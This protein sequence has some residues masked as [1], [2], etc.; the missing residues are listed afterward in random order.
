MGMLSRHPLTRLGLGVAHH[1]RDRSHCVLRAG[2]ERATG[3]RAAPDASPLP[4]PPWR[5]LATKALTGAD[6]RL[7]GVDAQPWRFRG[8]QTHRREPR[9][10]P[11]GRSRDPSSPSRAFRRRARCRRCR[12][13]SVVKAGWQARLPQASPGPRAGRKPLPRGSPRSWRRAG[14]RAEPP[15]VAPAA[16]GI[17]R[18]PGSYRRGGRDRA[19]CGGTPRTPAR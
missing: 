1:R 12:H 8:G 7:S 15:S 16:T 18:R 2:D 3:P 10:S 6:G 14:E 13:A 11:P 5:R 19:A 9:L 17:G 4:A